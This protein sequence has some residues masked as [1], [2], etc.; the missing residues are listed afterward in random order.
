MAF[1]DP[2]RPPR[3]PDPFE[4]VIT[5]L[6]T[7]RAEYQLTKWDYDNPEH[8]DA[9]GN[10]DAGEDRKRALAGLHEDSWFWVRG[11]LN[12]TGRIRQFWP[13]GFPESRPVAVRTEA[14]P[15][16]KLLAMQALL[17]LIATLIS[18]IE[19]LLRNGDVT[20]LPEPG[21]PSGQV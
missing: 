5:W 4:Q 16:A 12:Y 10:P 18:M 20:E 21:H 6:R 1:G 19:H 2:P 3:K 17:K 9:L 13:A 11:V 8:T 14:D 15:R 7:E